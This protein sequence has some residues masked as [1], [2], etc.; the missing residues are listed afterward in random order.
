ML[1]VIEK[2]LEHRGIHLRKFKGVKFTGAGTDHPGNIHSEMMPRV[3]NSCLVSL[4]HP[5]SLGT[6]VAFDTTFIKIPKLNVFINEP[7][8]RGFEKCLCSGLILWMG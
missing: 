8:P 7:L 5:S 4:D 6:W 3:R 1:S 2:D